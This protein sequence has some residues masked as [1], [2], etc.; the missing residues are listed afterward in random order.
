MINLVKIL[1]IT[2]LL[3]VINACNKY[4]EK[5]SNVYNYSEYITVYPKETVSSVTDFKF[6]LKNTPNVTTVDN[7]IITVVPKVAGNVLLDGNNIRF[8][9]SKKLNSNTIYTVTLHLS[10]LYNTI[11]D[12]LKNFTVKIKTNELFYNVSLQ[13][14]VVVTKN[15]YGVSGVINFSDVI[16]SEKLPE[17]IKAKYKNKEVVIKF[18]TNETFV[19]KVFFKIE[20]L[21][22]ANDDENLVVS[23][24]GSV[25]NSSSKG[26]QEIIVTGKKNFKILDVLVLDNDKQY[27][28]ISFSDP[29]IKLQD[30]NGLIQ[31]RN[32]QKRNFTYKVINNKVTIYPKL[33]FKNKVVIEIFKGIKNMDG[34]VLKN[35]YSK[36]LYFEELK[37]SVSFIKSGTII[38]NSTNL[39]INFNT[40][41]LKAVDVLVYKIYKDNVLQFL[42]DNNLD[43]TGNLRY[44]GRPEAKYTVNLS[45]KGVDLTKQNAFA[46]DLAEI[47]SVENGA[48]YRVELSFNQNYSNYTCNRTTNASTIIYGRKSVNI[49]EYDDPSY[50]NYNYENYKWSD[51]DNPCTN[52]YYYNKNISTNILAT[53]L[54]VIVKKGNNET[55]FIAVTNL[56]TTK[57]VVNASVT[58]YN[59]QQQAVVKATTNND[60]VVNFNGINNAFFAKI[61][62]GK[63]TTYI[64][65]NDGKALSMSKF[66]VSGTKLQKG[67]K[68]YIYGER[69]V[70]RPGDQLFLTFVLNDKANPIPEKHP[71]KFELINPQ[72]KITERKVL[73]KNNE[74]VYGYAPK[75]NQEAITGNWKLR[76]S[77]GGAVF[78]KTLKIETIKPNRLK[79][80]LKTATDFI[81]ADK[82]INGNVEVKWLHGAIAR[83]LKI[84]I[85]G[86]FRQTKTEFSTF[87]NYN[88]DDVTRNFRTEEFNVLNGA[89]NNDGETS[90]S[91]SPS[92]ESKAPGM[93]KASFITKVYENGGDFSTDVFSKKVSPYKTYVGLL[94]ASEQ[95][96]K[97]YLFTNEKYTF[98]VASVNENGVGVAN[99]LEVKLYKIS[100]RWW[101]S[102]NDNGLSNYDG[103]RY[104]EAYKTLQVK[105][106]AN[107]KG[108][109]DLKVS[110]N[111]WGRYLIK[112]TDKKSK[113]VTSNVVY[114]DWPSWYG[115]KKGNQD[116]TNATMLVFTTD[117]ESYEVDETATVKFPS[118]EE[119]RALITIENG[120]EVLDYFW[121]ETTAKQTAFKFP[122]L[123]N[124]TPNVFVNISLLQKHSQTVNDLPIRMYGSIPMLVNNSETILNPV[125]ELANEIRPESIVKI[126]IK[127]QKGKAMTYTIAL[128]DDGLLDL[129]RFKTPNPWNTFYA[130]QSLGVK[131]WDVFDDV[132][133]AY[134]GRVNQVLSIGG[135]ESEAGSKNK[136]ANRFKPMV[137]YL[138]PFNLENGASKTHTIKIPKYIGSV[139]AMVVATDATNNAYGSVEKTTLVRKPVMI[140]ASLPRKITPQ[141]T[142]TLPVNVFA[143]LPSVKKVKVTV[144]PNKSFTI[145]GNK[146]QVVTFNEP[147]EKMVYFTLKINDF[148]GIGKVQIDA[149]SEREK[150]SYEVE[151]DVLN[152]NPITTEVKNL[153]LKSNEKSMLNFTT[154]GSTGTNTAS[155]EL[156]TLPPMNFTKRMEYLIQYPHG[157]VEQTTSSAFPQ[158][159]LA[160]IFELSEEKQQDIE[161]N[162]KATIQ[163]LSDFQLANGGLSYWQGNAIAS[164]WG[165][166]YAGHFMLEAAKKGY[167][168][169]IG[170]RT[171]W[172]SYQKQQARNWR[173]N[174]TYENN[175]LSQAYRLYTLSLANSA[176]VASMNRLRETAD[177]SNEAKIQLASAYALI[178]KKS[179]AKDILNQLALNSYKKKQ[180]S[181]FGSEIR[182]KAM[183]LNTFILLNDETKAIKLAKEIAENLSDDLWMSTQTTAYSLLAMSKYALQNGENSGINAKYALNKNSVNVNT[184]KALFTDDLKA[185]KKENSITISNSSKG[186]LYVRIFNKG[187]LPVGE[188][189]VIQKNLETAV[190]YKTKEGSLIAPDNLSQGTNF[191]AEVTVKNVTNNRIENV[192]LTEYIPSGWEIINTRFTDFG[193]STTSSQVDF[194]DI[195]DA[196]ISNYF[197][198]REYETKTFKVLLNA[199]YLGTYYL[200]G[201]QV[202]AMY[203]NDYIARTKGKW[204][205]VVK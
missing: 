199:S 16:E 29:I 75:T 26:E 44:V 65:L 157:C 176:D 189:K 48:M 133:G 79:I 146:T 158:L 10:K 170:F 1:V 57:P 191:I 198:L 171:K 115:K 129:T 141:E 68:G 112:I 70:W 59:L 88:F 104:H 102:T 135:D 52:S 43:N 23:W 172:I 152:P 203:D 36:T 37:P 18:E 137:T 21:E 46:F 142:V 109:F 54:G 73:F 62:K 165:T 34:V 197:T 164:S 121:V 94:N 185:L 205:K 138:G 22:R 186:V 160:E 38:P 111:D 42:Q 118:S 110:E 86:K 13:Q 123:A 11:D 92:L 95:Q 150:A 66:D 166:S 30:L 188:E 28:E 143:M 53:N 139:R 114:F 8:V 24:N 124:Y 131:T 15:L 100:W 187:I 9:P 107:G 35:D 77:V 155:V 119:G 190:F 6:T 202:E 85:N 149:V 181:N 151:I 90:F 125:I 81:K 167:V 132:V 147:D 27:I 134:G 20:N 2:L 145:K 106:N 122:V 76:V 148:K 159:F 72:G 184:S 128:V 130:R 98:N 153:V 33:A 19:N 67:I 51:R 140:L 64:K 177:I 60:G 174:L 178:G 161:R 17:L 163:R 173:N 97:N 3:F 58:L 108:S 103:T 179:I 192:A 169:P 61:T 96:S 113:H 196:S 14:P 69:G 80:K 4:S 25:I 55:T 180:Y 156:S 7:T 87:K 193:N 41:N 39:K 47:L 204:I 105:T 82:D 162:I 40:V 154:F 49:K 71:I 117:K 83:N 183:A 45:N 31:F 144:Q 182:N 99:N 127:E 116:K 200:P 63:N 12:N 195:R 56:L 32:T 175:A 120:T 50:Y 126:K 93:L 78:N 5:D 201:V 91:V 74:N 136:K 194:T 84:D 89:L 101:W 168:L